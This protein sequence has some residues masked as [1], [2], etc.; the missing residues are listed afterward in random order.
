MKA[1]VATPFRNKGHRGPPQPVQAER[2]EADA[3]EALDA[4]MERYV[5]GD[6]AAFDALY[7]GVAGELLGYLL[8]V[9]RHRAQAEDLLQLTFLKLH[10]ARSAWIRGS[11]VRPYLFAI[12]RHAAIDALRSRASARVHLTPSGNLPDHAAD[13][14]DAAIDG[15]LEAALADAL[16]RLPAAHRQALALTREHEL[17]LREAGRVAGATETA[18]KLRVHRAFKALRRELADFFSGK[19]GS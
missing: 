7:R 6:L 13:V 2:P 10:T 11:R 1:T 5:D 4:A 14:D 16:A 15:H 18:M 19:E 12:A 9:V 17:T 8:T 3:D